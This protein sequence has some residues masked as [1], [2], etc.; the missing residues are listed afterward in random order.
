MQILVRSL[1]RCLE[2]SHK[3]KN[4]AVDTTLIEGAYAASAPRGVPGSKL[5]TSIGETLSDAGTSFIDSASAKVKQKKEEE[6]QGEKEF[7]AQL[8]AAAKASGLSDAEYDKFV[9]RL[10]PDGKLKNAFLDPDATP[11]EQS[12]ILRRISGMAQTTR[13]YE[14]IITDVGENAQVDGNI[15]NSFKNDPFGKALIGVITNPNATLETNPEDPDG[16]MGF[17]V[18]GKFMPFSE[19]Q[20]TLEDGRVDDTFKEGFRAINDAVIQD[21][22]K[23]TDVKY[24]NWNASLVKN[25]VDDLINTST[26][27]KSLATDPMLGGALSFEDHLYDDLVGKPYSKLIGGDYDLDDNNNGIIDGDEAKNIMNN[28][29]SDGNEQFLKEELSNYFTNTVVRKQGW[30]AGAGSRITDNTPTV[31]E[32]KRLKQENLQSTL[33]AWMTVPQMTS[34]GKTV[35]REL[36]AEDNLE[37]WNQRYDEGVAAGILPKDDQ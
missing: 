36:R 30:D 22:A 21:S 28:L 24:S 9:K 8:D 3:N 23:N 12:K 37:L 13:D 32:N 18:D 16:E 25:K 26:N 35:M 14:D 29:L 11:A 7:Q 27:L 1:A 5:A 15:S 34:D 31:A 19:V 20:K 4:M 33:K 10:G 17:T 6:K 2:L